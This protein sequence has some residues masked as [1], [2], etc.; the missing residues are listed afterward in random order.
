MNLTEIGWK[1]VNWICQNQNKDKQ[2]A[3]FGHCNDSQLRH[4]VLLFGPH[5]GLLRFKLQ[6]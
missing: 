5:L 2:Q 3:V 6:N 4:I 1:S